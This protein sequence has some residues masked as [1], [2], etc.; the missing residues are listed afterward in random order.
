[1]VE[2]GAGREVKIYGLNGLSYDVITRELL[3]Y[4]R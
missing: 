2:R 1:M 3:A 4:S